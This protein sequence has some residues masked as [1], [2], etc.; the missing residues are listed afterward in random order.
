M[1]ESLIAGAQHLHYIHVLL[2]V[3]V[4]T[5]QVLCG[6]GS[7][8]CNPVE[9]MSCREKLKLG[10]HYPSWLLGDRFPLPVNSARVDG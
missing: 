9:L 1:N 2:I 4:R 5:V 10:F 7:V 6:S 3:A 8:S